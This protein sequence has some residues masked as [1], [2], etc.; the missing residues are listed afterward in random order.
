MNKK[1]KTTRYKY[2][3]ES[4]LEDRFIAIHNNT[5][6]YDLF[7]KNETIDKDNIKVGKTFNWTIYEVLDKLGNSYSIKSTLE[8]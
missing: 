7:Y 1:L 6:E 5:G 3:I 4:V 8:F 2:T